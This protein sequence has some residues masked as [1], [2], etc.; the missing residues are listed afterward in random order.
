MKANFQSFLRRLSQGPSPNVWVWIAIICGNWGSYCDAKDIMVKACLGEPYGIAMIE[1]P[2]S[3]PVAGRPALPLT[4]RPVDDSAIGAGSPLFSVSNDLIIEIGPPSERQLPPAGG[5][6]LLERVGELLKELSGDESLHF[7][8]VSRRVFFLFQGD[9][10]LQVQLSDET[11][12]YGKIELQPTQNAAE[13]SELFSLWWDA[14]NEKMRSQIDRAD[15]PTMVEIYL[16]SMLARK[17]QL[18]LPA[19]F[20]ETAQGDDQLLNTLK[21]IGGAE[22]VSD[23]VFRSAAAGP[24]ESV[25]VNT[26]DLPDPPRWQEM[27]LKATLGQNAMEPIA[28]RVPPECFYIR[29]GNFENYLWFKDLS[30]ANGGDLSKLLTLRGIERPSADRMEKQLAFKVTKLSRILGGTLVED[31]AI[32]GRDLYLN[33]GAAVGVLFQSSSQFLLQASMQVERRQV[34]AQNPDATLQNIEVAGQTVSFLSTPDNRVRSF[35]GI[36]GHYLLVTNSREILQRFFEVGKTGRSLAETPSF[37]LARRY[38]PLERDDTVFAYFSPEMFQG[39]V[40]PRYMIELR[41]RL[42]AKADLVMVQLARLLADSKQDASPS[43]GFRQPS[44]IE[45]LVEQKLLPVGI[46][47]RF[48]G[49]GVSEVGERVV[50]T[51]RGSRGTF[52]P[53]SDVQIEQVTEAEYEWYREIAASYSARFTN[54]DPVMVGVQRRGSSDGGGPQQVVIHA[55]VA[56]WDPGKYGELA[57]QLGPPTRTEMQVAPDDIVSIQG[58][59]ASEWL[60][61]PTHLFAAIKDT[62]PP[63]PKQFAGPLKTYFSLKQIP[64]YLGA[65]PK[66]GAL[67]R[68]PLGL[69]KGRP[70][71]PGMTRIVGG[72]YRYNDG[73]FS[74]ISFQPN[75]LR[76]SLPHLAAVD[77]NHTAQLRLRIGDLGGSRLKDW[78]NQQL[79][80]RAS[81]SSAAGAGYLDLLTQSLPI[82]P[83]SA[84]YVAEEILDGKIQCTLG[85]E[86]QLTVDSEKVWTSTAWDDRTPPEE[87]PENYQTPILRWFH[88]AQARLTQLDDRLIADIIL[89]LD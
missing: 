23:S 68:L 28:K 15:Y 80:Q 10:N 22:E 57:E 3:V 56:P 79:Y 8:T 46:G 34:L 86:Y 48:D 53:I 62:V 41:R 30:E 38:M 20:Y 70:V 17:N 76:S 55:E 87:A 19:W 24:R 1:I 63:D 6:R 25:S 58:H 83:E 59:V 7:Q 67:D 64:G 2:V 39:L 50:D 82:K 14:F 29:Y 74:V 16:L 85:G 89:D 32:I 49:S 51:L 33:D 21:L 66:P 75:V 12:G 65:W 5:G 18:P 71:G 45:Q 13:R 35:L 36:D 69:G 88:G 26:R 9:Q 4:V 81:E 42:Y 37:Q 61:P 77:S 43:S 72:L 11:R 60:G 27:D 84:L 54:F 44:S 73:Q 78:V 52:L 40:S 31:Q 47:E